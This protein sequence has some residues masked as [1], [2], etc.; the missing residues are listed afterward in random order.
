V[1]VS[2]RN[3]QSVRFDEVITKDTDETATRL[4]RRNRISSVSCGLCNPFSYLVSRGRS[5][6]TH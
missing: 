6:F 4:V 2:V 3:M 5:P 1:I